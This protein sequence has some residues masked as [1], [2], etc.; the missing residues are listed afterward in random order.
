MNAI[1]RVFICLSVYL[2]VYL[3]SC[4]FIKTFNEVTLKVKCA[5][6]PIRQNGITKLKCEVCI[7]KLYQISFISKLYQLMLSRLA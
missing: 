2:F 6:K 7:S 1:K 3:I 5:R 4:E